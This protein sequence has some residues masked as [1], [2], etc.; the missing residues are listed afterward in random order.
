MNTTLSTTTIDP[1]RSDDP[2]FDPQ[3]VILLSL[4]GLPFIFYAYALCLRSCCSLERRKTKPRELIIEV[5]RTP[6][7]LT[8]LSSSIKQINKKNKNVIIKSDCTICLEKINFGRFRK[9]KFISLECS[10]VFHYYCLRDWVS[11]EMEKGR[12]A[13]CPICRGEIKEL[14][15]KEFVENTFYT[16]I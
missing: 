1:F 9:D 12:F 4:C 5:N 8:S 15:N 3:M 10:H 11:S 2:P 7:E 16:Y 13:K 6:N 14:K